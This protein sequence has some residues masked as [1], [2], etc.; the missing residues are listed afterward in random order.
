MGSVAGFGPQLSPDQ[1]FFPVDKKFMRFYSKPGQS[2]PAETLA[3]IAAFHQNSEESGVDYRPHIYD[4]A[5]KTH[6]LVDS[7]SAV[8]AWPPEPGDLEVP[9]LHLK[10]V[11]GSKIKCF[12]H[13]EVDIRINRKNYRFKVIK[14][15]VECPILGWDFIRHFKF[16][17]LWNQFGDITINDPKANISQPLTY[18]ALSVEKSSSL[19]NIRSSNTDWSRWS[20]S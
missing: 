15:Q 20:S 14:A 8:S 6:I 10:A 12:G 9:N 7:G 19:K 16:N 5:S 11:N 3:A 18:R 17:F 2:P 13:K 4:S 1:N